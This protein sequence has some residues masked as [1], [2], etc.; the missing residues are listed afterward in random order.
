VPALERAPLR[1]NRWTGSEPFTGTIKGLTKHSA[2]DLADLTFVNGQMHA[3]FTGDSAGGVLTIT[4]GSQT[5]KLD[6]VGDYLSS[7]WSLSKDGSGGTA[8]TDPAIV[9]IHHT[10]D[11]G[12]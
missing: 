2:V 3:T 6:L 5:V 7:S 8:V 10:H 11:A 12:I 4:D 1:L 9:G